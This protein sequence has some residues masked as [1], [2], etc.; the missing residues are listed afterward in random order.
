[1][2]EPTKEQIE[3]AYV[4]RNRF[5]PNS[6]NAILPWLPLLIAHIRTQENNDALERAAT[7]CEKAAPVGG[8]AWDESQAACYAALTHVAKHFRSMKEPT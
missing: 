8:R 7:A 3:E 1:M 4:L 6:T 2:G 5:L